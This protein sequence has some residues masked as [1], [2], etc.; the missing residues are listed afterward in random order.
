MDKL[1]GKEFLDQMF[2]I[3]KRDDIETGHQKA[4]ELMIDAVRSL[5]ADLP[6]SADWMQGVDCFLKMGKWYA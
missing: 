5:A 3:A 2:E 6:F 4:D 1:T